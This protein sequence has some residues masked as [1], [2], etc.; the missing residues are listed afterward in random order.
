LV[1]D[2]VRPRIGDVVATARGTGGL[3]D[4]SRYPWELRLAGFHGALTPAELLVPLLQY[5]A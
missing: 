1:R 5:R 3:F 4:R 2:E